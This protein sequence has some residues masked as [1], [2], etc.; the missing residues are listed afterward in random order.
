V[1]RRIL[2]CRTAEAGTHLF[3]CKDCDTRFPIYNS[4]LDRHCP[5]C[6]GPATAQW[7]AARQARMLPTPHFQV[8]FTL[9]AALRGIAL[10]NQQ[11]VYALLFRVA[12]SVLRDLASQH[13]HARLGILSVLHTWTSSLGYHP[14]LHCLVT[15]GGLHDD[16][17]RWVA[18]NP[19][20]L[21]SQKAMGKMVRGRFLQE[22]VNAF[23]RGELE[24]RGDP[25]EAERDFRSTTR[26]LANKHKRWVVHVEPPKGRPVDHVVGYLAR[27][28]KRVAI[29]DSR[30]LRITATTVTIATRKGPLVLEGSEFVRRFLLHVLP[31]QFRKIRYQGLYAPG[32]AKVRLEAARELLGPI[33]S[34]G[35]GGGGGDGDGDNE[36][37]AVTLSDVE[38]ARERPAAVG[39][40]PVC[41]SGKT[42]RIFFLGPGV[43]RIARAPP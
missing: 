16:G 9:P 15:A 13:F 6:Q 10:A 43:L 38:V 7:L 27:Y 20:W 2:T 8:V 37:Q 23:D 36:V 42:Y 31:R 19:G 3:V 4:C 40:C 22:L 11:I 17:E 35:S 26:A 25:V 29:G 12:A 5:Q 21:F 18:S 34:G 24:L 1:L 32:N 41:G 28:V 33:A 39:R 14:H 30:I